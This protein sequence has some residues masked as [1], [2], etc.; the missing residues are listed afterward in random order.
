MIPVIND[1]DLYATNI[2]IVYLNG[3]CCKTI[4]NISGTK[5][6]S[7]KGSAMI[8]VWELYGLKRSGALWRPILAN[9]LGKD[10]VGCTSSESNKD[11][12]IKRKVFP[13]GKRYCSIIL[14]YVNDILLVSKYNSTDINYLS[15]I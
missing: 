15:N 13:N 1:L 7:D 14:I 2:G 12:W 11:T 9:T 10:G 4:W 3:P 5:F 6:S 8:I